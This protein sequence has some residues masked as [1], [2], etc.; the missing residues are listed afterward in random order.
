MSRQTKAVNVSLPLDI[1][2][3][4]EELS[5]KKACQEAIL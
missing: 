1:Y 2:Q 3:E 5:E 4:L